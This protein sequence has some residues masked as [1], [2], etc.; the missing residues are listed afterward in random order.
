[1]LT[2]V[3]V[4][5]CWHSPYLHLA[6]SEMWCWS[7]GR[8]ILKKNCLCV[9]V[10]CTVIM[11]HKGTSSS[12]RLVDCIGLWSC[13]FSSLVFQASLCRQS[14]WC[15]ICLHPFLHVL[16]SWAWWDCPLTWLTNHRPSVLWHCCFGH[17][18][19]K[20]VSEMTCNVLSGML[21]PT[22]AIPTLLTLVFVTLSLLLCVSIHCRIHRCG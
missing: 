2:V 9:T 3:L 7:G 6:T 22:I 14:S 10:L 5:H 12:Y 19:H 16:V 13:L 15:Y 11:M 17:L 4:P 8:V 20:I 1:M 21:H 18:T